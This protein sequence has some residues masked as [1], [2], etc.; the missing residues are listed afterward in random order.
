MK[1]IF[2]F[3]M[4]L[5]AFIFLF[6][7]GKNGGVTKPIPVGN[8]TWLVKDIFE[9]NSTNFVHYVFTYNAQGQIIMFSDSTPASVTSYSVEY[10]SQGKITSIKLIKGYSNISVQ[11]IIY[12]G[13][14]TFVAQ[15][16]PNDTV[17]YPMAFYSWDQ[18]SE[19]EID[20]VEYFGRWVSGSPYGPNARYWDY[21]YDAGGGLHSLSI[22]Y[23][24]QTPKPLWDLYQAGTDSAIANPFHKGRTNEQNFLYY[25][26]ARSFIDDITIMSN[27]LPNGIY[28][29]YIDSSGV[30]NLAERYYYTYAL[31]SNKNVSKIKLFV[32]GDKPYFSAYASYN[33]WNLMYEQH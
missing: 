8:K 32:A 17:N 20:Q 3:A 31:D 24:G 12:E 29:A 30:Q 7:C 15:V 6:G 14:G 5:S 18:K 28:Q 9:G 16:I 23:I 27:G 4:L 10:N 11:T 13:S 22:Y 25:Y 21:F 19:N 26:F 33:E 1:K 2:V